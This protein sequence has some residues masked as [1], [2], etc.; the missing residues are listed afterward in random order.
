MVVPL[1]NVTTLIEAGDYVDLVGDVV[2]RA[3]VVCSSLVSAMA[4]V[5]ARMHT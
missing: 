4:I 3:R 1:P 5:A 2:Q